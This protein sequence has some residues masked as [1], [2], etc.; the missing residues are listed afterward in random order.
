MILRLH[1]KFRPSY[2]IYVY[3][4]VPVWVYVRMYFEVF[5][6]NREHWIP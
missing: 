2:F 5:A 4:C 6:E 3:V 1:R